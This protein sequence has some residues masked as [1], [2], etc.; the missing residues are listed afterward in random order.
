MT[1]QN[2]NNP[3]GLQTQWRG[4]WHLKQTEQHIYVKIHV[5]KSEYV[6]QRKKMYTSSCRS[7]EL[8]TVCPCTAGS[9]NFHSIA[10]KYQLTALTWQHAVGYECW[11]LNSE[12]P[13]NTWWSTRGWTNGESW[14]VSA[15]FHSGLAHLTSGLMRK[16]PFTFL[17]F[18][19]AQSRRIWLNISDDSKC[20]RGRHYLSRSRRSP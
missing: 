15:D 3:N 20:P 18:A 7:K 14:S 4:S 6:Q 17:P 8:A 16:Q 12:S 10:G 13:I 9:L 5:Q 11:R 1:G 19:A 2:P